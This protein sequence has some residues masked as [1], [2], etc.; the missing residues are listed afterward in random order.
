MWFELGGPKWVRR[1]LDVEIEKANG[2]VMSETRC[3]HPDCQE[4]KKRDAI[5]AA[6]DYSNRPDQ[7][8]LAALRQLPTGNVEIDKTKGK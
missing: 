6:V 3:V 4:Q 1:L 7:M 2:K 5:K 8:I